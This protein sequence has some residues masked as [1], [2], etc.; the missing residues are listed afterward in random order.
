MGLK[1]KLNTA[2]KPV[3]HTEAEEA[4]IKELGIDRLRDPVQ[5]PLPTSEVLEVMQTQEVD[6]TGA[7]YVSMLVK[8][9]SGKSYKIV[10]PQSYAKLVPKTWDWN[11]KRLKVAEMIAQGIPIT[12]ISDTEGLPSRQVIYGWLQHPEFK[13]HV[14]GLV[15][16][17]GWANKQE[18]IAGLNKLTNTLFK[19]V[20]NEI[21][22]VKLTDKSI[23]AVLSS[24]QLIAKQLGVEKEELVEQS[25]IEQNTNVSGAI[26][27]AAINLGNVLNEK[28]AEERAALE[29]EFNNM[30]DDIIRAITGEKE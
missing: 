20:M 9:S 3:R 21:D 14:D 22:Q 27:V 25:K 13:E 2:I 18:R 29:A 26:G 24:I 8:G 12:D 17:T 30:G 23:G 4:M 6:K 11:E 10:I 1:R 19:K 5:K 15:L 7:D 16:E 28:T